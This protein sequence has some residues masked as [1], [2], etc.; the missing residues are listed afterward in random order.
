MLCAKWTYNVHYDRTYKEHRNL[1]IRKH[2]T[3]S[4]SGTKPFYYFWVK[5]FDIS[6]RDTI[7]LCCLIHLA[8]NSSGPHR[9]QVRLASA[10]SERSL[11]SGLSLVSCLNDMEGLYPTAVAQLADTLTAPLQRGKTPSPQRVSWCDTKQSDGEVRVMLELWAIQ[12]IPSLPSLLYPLWPG[13]VTPDRFLFMGQIELK[14][15]LMLNWT[16]WN[17]TVLYAKQVCLKWNCFWHWN[18]TY[19]ILNCLK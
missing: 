17:R 16:A 19:A 13:V 8:S 10:S 14:C 2:V 5:S 12:S 7:L 6:R 1:G 11:T 4:C 18:C 9:A 3:T 15:V